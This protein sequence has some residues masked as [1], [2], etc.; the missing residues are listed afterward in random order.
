MNNLKTKKSGQKLTALMLIVVFA[1]PFV[2][3]WVI[4][5]FTDFGSDGVNNSHGR[6]IMPPGQVPDVELIDPTASGNQLTLHGKW[7]LVYIASVACA[8]DCEHALEI[9][10]GTR[11]VLGNESYRLQLLLVIDKTNLTESVKSIL[12]EKRI[13]TLDRIGIEGLDNREDLAVSGGLIE[14]RLFLIDPL[15]NLM[16]LYSTESTLAGVIKDIKRLLRNSRI[17]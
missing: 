17:G 3:A 5:S 13:L 2:G 12:R 1:L 9:M 16:M 7:S 11:A 10:R 6:L 14:D 15:G 8:S 4:Y